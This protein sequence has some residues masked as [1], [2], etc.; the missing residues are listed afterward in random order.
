MH[1]QLIQVQVRAVAQ[2][3]RLCLPSMIERGYG[4]VINIA[5]LAGLLLG[6][7]D[8]HALSGGQAFLVKFLESLASEL[9]G[10]GVNVRCVLGFTPGTEFHMT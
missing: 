5:S 7:P 10:T 6:A 2:L 4:R 9:V 1:A 8:Q 3:T